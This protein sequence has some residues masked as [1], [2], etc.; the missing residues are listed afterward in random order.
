MLVWCY[1]SDRIMTSLK[2]CCANIAP[3]SSMSEVRTSR[4]IV[5]NSCW[6]DAI[7]VTRLWQRKIY[8]ATTS[9]QH[10]Q[11]RRFEKSARCRKI[12][13]V[14]ML[15]FRPDNDIT[16]L[17]SHQ[18]RSNINNIED[19]KSRQGV[20]KLMLCWCCYFDLIMTSQNYCRT[21][22]V[23]TSTISK[24]WKVGKVSKN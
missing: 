10:Q 1:N 3:L 11:Y 20:E 14:L 18:H 22:I 7:I 23:P 19:L 17:L 5:Q 2:W 24:I 4:Q 8:V 6:A 12:D 13:V 9:H 21:N 16:K 15:L